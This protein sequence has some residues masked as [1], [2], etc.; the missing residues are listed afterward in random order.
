MLTQQQ[1]QPDYVVSEGLMTAK[2][3]LGGEYPEVEYYFDGI[4][5]Y[6]DDYSASEIE[7]CA[8]ALLE[9]E[10]ECGNN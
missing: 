1:Q 8:D 4:L 5:I 10:A 6:P 7:F 2:V 3:Y 9:A